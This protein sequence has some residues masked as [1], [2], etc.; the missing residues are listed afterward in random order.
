MVIRF[1]IIFLSL[2]F[3]LISCGRRSE[4][5]I[6]EDLSKNKGE[7]T[8][9]TRSLPLDRCVRL[10]EERLGDNLTAKKLCSCF[11]IQ[12]SNNFKEEV[13]LHFIEDKWDR[14]NDKELLSLTELYESCFSTGLTS[15]S[16][17]FAGY[18]PEIV[19]V[20]VKT[21]KQ[22]L[23]SVNLQEDYDLDLLTNCLVEAI[24]QNFT[25]G[26]VISTKIMNS[27][28][29]QSLQERCADEAKL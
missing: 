22:N 26:E 28:E 15:D 23:E 11:M 9:S 6:E 24:Q 8:L 13:I 16:A 25:V 2:N 29:F 12:A 3:L 20:L 18:S 21:I 27:P 14:I 7:K 5:I 17:K 10:Y 19:E 1:Y 4:P